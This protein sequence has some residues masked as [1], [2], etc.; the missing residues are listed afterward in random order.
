M[1]F[2][3]IILFSVIFPAFVFAAPPR[4]AVPAP[5][6]APVPSRGIDIIPSQP[7]ISLESKY[8][9]TRS[10][11]SKMPEG[12]TGR[13]IRIDGPAKKSIPPPKGMMKSRVDFM[14]EVAKVMPSPKGNP[15]DLPRDPSA[16][17]RAVLAENGIY[18]SDNAKSLD[19]FIVNKVGE[20]VVVPPEQYMKLFSKFFKDS[21]GAVM[22]GNL[23][24]FTD[25]LR[26]MRGR[27][28]KAWDAGVEK[29]RR[30]SEA[31]N[32]EAQD[33]LARL[34]DRMKAGEKIDE[35]YP[36]IPALVTAM[37]VEGYSLFIDEGKVMIML[38]RT[39]EFLLLGDFIRSG[40]PKS[41]HF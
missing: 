29:A 40:F 8:T 30:P 13:I 5:R 15:A 36:E 19:V 37:E 31:I 34:D 35:A 6:P 7:S 24:D 28:R 18:L 21:S 2:F 38:D 14:G 16:R 12:T 17:T 25:N 1:K 3:F 4:P 32:P 10:G 33:M 39:G 9:P 27:Y 22:R 26:R 23:K 41:D 11:L 20:T